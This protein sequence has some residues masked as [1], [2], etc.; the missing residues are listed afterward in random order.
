M[1][2]EYGTESYGETWMLWQYRKGNGLVKRLANSRISVDGACR[3]PINAG[4][5]IAK[6]LVEKC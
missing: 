2:R 5:F 3:V 1:R 4:G 6:V